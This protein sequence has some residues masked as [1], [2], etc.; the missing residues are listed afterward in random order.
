MGALFVVLRAKFYYFAPAFPMLLAAGS[1][2]IEDALARWPRARLA[3][4]A[5]VL[6]GGAATAPLVIPALPPERF[7]AYQRA[8]G[9]ESPRMERHVYREMPQ[10]FADEF[11]WP[12]LA[13][14]VAAVAASLSPTER[15]HAAVYA[16]N[17]GEA[18]ALS[19][20][21]RRLGVPRAISGHNN[22]FLWGPGDATVLIIVGGDEADH[23]QACGTL[24]LARRLPPHPYVMPYED[25]L[26]LYICRDL[27][28]SIA[29]LWP[30]VRHFE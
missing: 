12:E 9:I 20:L 14:N 10:H 29:E 1:V 25:A 5:L 8:L 21:G 30:R 4:P 27:R 17:Y 26:P 23:R 15:A 16:Q 24:E 19:F 28:G 11:G 13:Q 22:Y 7:L 3:L 6:L 2:A 18:S